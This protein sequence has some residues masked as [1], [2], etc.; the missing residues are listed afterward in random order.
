LTGGGSKIVNTRTAE[1][2]TKKPPFAAP[3]VIILAVVDGN[4][5]TAIHRIVRPQMVIGRADEADFRIDDDEVSGRHCM[6]RVDGPVCTLVEL[7]S[8]NGTWVN[9]RRVPRGTALRLRHLDMIRIG[10]TRVMVLSG[11]FPERSG[12]ERD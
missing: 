5:P 1:R 6:I 7:E 10:G 8:L 9:A 11:R 2:P 3:H 4:D 12:E